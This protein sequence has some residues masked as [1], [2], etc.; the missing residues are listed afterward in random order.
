MLSVPR[1]K[2]EIS[3]CRPPLFCCFCLFC[4]PQLPAHCLIITFRL[5]EGIEPDGPLPTEANGELMV[6][7]AN[8][9]I[10][11]LREV[12][13]MFPRRNYQET[14]GTREAKHI[15]CL[16]PGKLS[17]NVKCEVS[18]TYHKQLLESQQLMSRGISLWTLLKRQF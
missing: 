13:S 11:K 18:Q 4:F 14:R 5:L 15:L 6:P 17:R 10:K 2:S 9:Q 1:N 12:Q 16:S 7:K 3:I 8:H